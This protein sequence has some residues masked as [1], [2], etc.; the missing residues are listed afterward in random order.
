MNFGNVAEEFQLDP[1]FKMNPKSHG[2]ITISKLSS[3][4]CYTPVS[5]LSFSCVMTDKC[6]YL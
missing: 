1:W 3:I 2:E 5:G 6:W 4:V